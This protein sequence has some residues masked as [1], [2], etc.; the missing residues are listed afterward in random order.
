[1]NYRDDLWR[2][3]AAVGITGARRGRIVAEI[4]DHL[5]CDPTADLGAPDALAAQFA[6]E[7]GT[8]RALRA[9]RW[10]FAALALAGLLF[11]GAFV[12]SPAA[13]FGAAPSGAPL[14]GSVARVVVILAPQVAFVAGLLAALRTLRRRR[15]T[16]IPAAEARVIVR[17]A[18][19]GFAFGLTTMVGLGVVALEFH[20]QLPSAW[21]TYALI[22]AGTGV[23]VLL[24]ALPSLLAARR[25][26]PVASGEPGDVFVDLGRWVPARLRGHPWRLAVLIAAGVALAI[27]AAGGGADDL[28]D[29]AARGIADALACLLGFATLGRYLGLWRPAASD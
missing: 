19:V 8:D 29:G 3:L 2:E 11:G 23:A 20:D 18:S 21:Y 14:P 24:A 22:A 4:E 15:T 7:L 1:M 9:A 16:V 25:L 13:A 26:R 5:D 28:Y 17:R 10:T 6:N 12:G 27:T